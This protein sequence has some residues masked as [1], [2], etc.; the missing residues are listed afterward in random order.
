MATILFH[1]RSK[2]GD[3]TT[4][5]IKLKMKGFGERGTNTQ[6]AEQTSV[7]N[8]TLPLPLPLFPL[9]FPALHLGYGCRLECLIPPSSN[10]IQTIRTPAKEGRKAGRKD[11][12]FLSPRFLP[13]LLFNV[14]AS[15]KVLFLLCIFCF[16][17][18]YVCPQEESISSH[19]TTITD[20]C[21]PLPCGCW[22]LKP[23]PPEE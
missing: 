14:W 4:A 9:P 6:I 19:G 17:C 1:W 21:E 12:A 18:M 3:L 7:Q 23:G 5:K 20:S 15:F 22:K 8:Q 13:P 11:W 10:Q 16:V 2:S